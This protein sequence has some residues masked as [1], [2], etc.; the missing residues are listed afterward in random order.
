MSFLSR[1]SA[2]SRHSSS[3]RN[4]LSRKSAKSSKPSKSHLFAPK[5]P[6]SN[7]KW[8]SPISCKNLRLRTPKWSTGLHKLSNR[9]AF[10]RKCFR[11]RCKEFLEVVTAQRAVPR[12]LSLPMAKC[13][14]A[15]E[16]GS[17]L[18]ASN[19]KLKWPCSEISCLRRGR[20][21]SSQFLNT[22]GVRI[23]FR[24]S[25]ARWKWSS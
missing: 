22:P 1:S 16:W 6:S 12:L 23:N 5:T 13:H 14:R 8:N 3:K 25:Y 19:L 18:S 17:V 21:E 15:E 24:R 9:S 20:S 11:I 2:K 7:A 4:L 10:T